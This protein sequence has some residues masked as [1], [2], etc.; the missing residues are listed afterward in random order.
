[1][2]DKRAARTAYKEAGDRWVIYA[3]RTGGT[4]WVGATPNLAA[5]EHRAAFQFRMGQARPAALQAA[6]DGSFEVSELEALDPRLGP[7]GR[8]EAIKARR[9]AWAARLG[10]AELAR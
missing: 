3:L 10:A 1:M 9:A 2:I 5:A 4:V 7:L 6:W 8:D